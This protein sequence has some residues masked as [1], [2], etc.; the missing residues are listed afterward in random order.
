M[1][2]LEMTIKLW[3]AFWSILLQ[4]GLQQLHPPS[5]SVLRR[6]QEDRLG[7]ELQEELV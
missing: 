3:H 1:W 2:L 4:A 7:S 5:T 6:S